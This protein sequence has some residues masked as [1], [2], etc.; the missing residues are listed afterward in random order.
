MKANTNYNN[1]MFCAAATAIA[2]VYVV[3]IFMPG[4]DAIAQLSGEL[5]A[6]TEFIQQ[7]EAMAPAVAIT[8]TEYD[9]TRNYIRAWEDVAPSE[10][11]IAELF[12]RINLLVKQ[13]GATTTRFD[14]QPALRYERVSSV[15]VDL[16]C[17]GSFAQVCTMLRDLE[18]LGETIWVESLQMEM[19]EKDGQNVQCEL[20]LAVFADNLDSSDQVDRSE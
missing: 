7:V 20:T 6:K 2:V 9:N 10:D 18:K 12:G 11:D 14:P 15:P 5:A 17:V 8:Q 1:W 19:A 4:E 3:F 13:S 16:A